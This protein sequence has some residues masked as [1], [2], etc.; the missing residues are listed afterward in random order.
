MKRII[1][2]LLLFLGNFFTS[3][4]LSLLSGREI[5]EDERISSII[6]NIRGI[7]RENREV[8]N[9]CS[10]IIGELAPVGSGLENLSREDILR[11]RNFFF[12]VRDTPTLEI[13][14]TLCTKEDDL[15]LERALLL[16]N[17]IK[18]TSGTVH[19]NLV[20]YMLP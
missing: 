11:Y 16:S 2:M 7:H 20:F 17:I 12:R 3:D 19:S 14:E 10:K 13:I 9:Y 5:S 8:S 1:F 4:C 6:T 18:N 15:E